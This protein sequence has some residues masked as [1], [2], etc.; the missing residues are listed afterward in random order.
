VTT[1]TPFLTAEDLAVNGG[2][3][4]VTEALPEMYP[5]GMRI[6]REEEEA[7]L[8]VLRSKRLFRY[9]GPGESASAV[10][11]FEHAVEERLNVDHALAVSSGSMALAAGLAALG[12]GP[13]DEV[14][15]P[16]YTWIASAAAAVFLGAVPVLAE[17]D[18]A[19]TLDAADVERRITPRTKV[20]LV[21]HMRGG[22][23]NMDA[24][25][26]LARRK[27]LRILE[28]T[29]Q[30]FGASYHGRSLG[31]IGDVG[32][33]SLQFNKILTSGE[34]GVVTTN[35][36]ALYER[37]LLFH[38]VAA[39]MR[40]SLKDKA[41]FV[42]TTGRMSE[43]QGAVAGAQLPKLTAILDDMRENFRRIKGAVA[44]AASAA[45]VTWRHQWDE[46]GDADLALIAY[47]P[48]ASQ[49]ADI[50]AA[51]KAEGVPASRLF[52][53]ATPDYH[54]AYHWE[55]LI[56]QR[57][58]S[59][60]TPWDF[61]PE[62]PAIDPSSCPRTHQLLERAIQIDVS[63]E[64]TDNQVAQLSRGIEKVFASISLA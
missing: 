33:F 42:G 50:V 17:V 9:Y 44:E 54:V 58:W 6:G 43:L 63:P 4:A 8:E 11:R 51:L 57:S 53:P 7:V 10:E 35:D 25:T 18:E 19:L 46:E 28:D 39:S 60:T 16:A 14:I 34:G 41:T 36:E 21:V 27:N 38:D 1:S 48:D 5:G 2:A 24:L 31:T 20:I 45:G 22:A 29:A 15:V 23:S 30:A 3:P 62:L 26:E 49:A 64:L 32:I 40:S 61:D 13:G 56:A 47:L 52:D 55:P 12:V 59:S 37:A